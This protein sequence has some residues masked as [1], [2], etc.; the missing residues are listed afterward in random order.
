MKKFITAAALLAA[1]GAL[2]S[3]ATTTV[4]LVSLVA[5]ST[6]SMVS[7]SSGYSATTTLAGYASGGTATDVSAS[8][9]AAYLD[10]D[11]GLYYGTGNVT[12]STGYSTA[13]TVDSS[14]T[15]N[16]L[17]YTNGTWIRGNYLNCWG[18]LVVSVADILKQNASAT[19]DDLTSIDFTVS[20]SSDGEADST[21][22]TT[23]WIITDGEATAVATDAQTGS[24]DISSAEEDSTIV[25]LVST[26]TGYGNAAITATAT[27]PE[28]SAFGLLAGVGALALVAA[29]RRRSRKA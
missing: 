23:V 20:Y 21:L 17:S 13:P 27:I 5:S 9:V 18:A 10:V 19:I 2:A 29:R 11:T 16:T 1:S 7:T 15:P 26:G 8:D 4:D 24:I 22:F 12:T 14:T 28:P 6:A 25:I 3:A